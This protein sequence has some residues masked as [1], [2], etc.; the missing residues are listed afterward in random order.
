MIYYHILHEKEKLLYKKCGLSARNSV[1]RYKSSFSRESESIDN[2][3]HL[4]LISLYMYLNF[5]LN[6]T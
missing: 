5:I 2:F 4:L 3:L 1:V 6:I